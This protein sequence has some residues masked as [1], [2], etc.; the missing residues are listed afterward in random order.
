MN[1][2]FLFAGLQIHRCENNPFSGQKLE[3]FLEAIS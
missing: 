2:G 1:T 3:D